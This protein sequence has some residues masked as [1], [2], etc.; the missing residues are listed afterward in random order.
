MQLKIDSKS[1]LVFDLDDT[2]FQEMDYLKS[3]Y[4][5][6]SSKLAATVKEDL[7]DAMLK[8]YHARENVFQWLLN[9]Y[10]NNFPDLSLQWLLKEYRDHVPSI[11]LSETTAAFFD[12]LQKRKVLAGL[13]TDG[14]SVTQRNKLRA[15]GLETFFSD[16]IISE[17]F[18]SEKPDER[19][20]LFFEKKYPEMDFYFFGDNTSKDFIVPARLGWTTIC[21]R[22]AGNH[23]H[24]Q[25]FDENPMP[26]YIISGFE[27][28]E[29]I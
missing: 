27:E 22:N 26:D 25:S 16:I 11:K 9:E 4:A 21:M 8:K 29:L 28:I 3:A 13:I 5:H 20:Y 7:Y 6:I 15:L 24:P 2:I 23:I 1:F 17:E 12:Q 18:G 19:N 10:Q 14:R